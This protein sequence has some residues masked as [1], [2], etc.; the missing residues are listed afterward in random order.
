MKQESKLKSVNIQLVNYKFI[1]EFNLLTFNYIDQ[2]L[3]AVNVKTFITKKN[4]EMVIEGR[5][6]TVKVENKSIVRP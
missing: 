4:I 1:F 2:C 6:L 5:Y 3:H